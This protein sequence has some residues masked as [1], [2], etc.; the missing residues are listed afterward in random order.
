METKKIRPANL[1]GVTET[2]LI[3]LYFRVIESQ[4]SD[5]II[6][7]PAAEEIL[8]KLEHDF[9]PYRKLHEDQ[10]FTA[11]RIRQF[12]RYVLGFLKKHPTGTVVSMG[13]GL[14]TRFERVDNGK[15]HWF[16]LDLPEVIETRR[17]LLK[18][19]SRNRY[20]AKSVFQFS[21][22]DNVAKSKGPYLF[23][24]EGVLVYLPPDKIKSLVLELTKRFKGSELVFDCMSKLSMRMHN[25]N[26]ILQKTQASLH[27]YMDD[28]R[29]MEAWGN[30]IRLLETWYYLDETE[31][32]TRNIRWMR[33][34]PPLNRLAYILRYQLG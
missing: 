24:T 14:D 12:D 28:R 9:S 3:S 26:K 8:E 16:D 33:W 23:I 1:H 25:S 13:S 27:F 11:L 6:K 18:E 34:I 22:M 17:K 29:E 7:D 4:R 21:W 31:E 2:M 15:G 30:G 20:I 19:S 32:R 10:T 5:G